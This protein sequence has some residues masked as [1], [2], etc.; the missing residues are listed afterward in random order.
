MAGLKSGLIELVEDVAPQV[1]WAHWMLNRESLVAKE[2]LCKCVSFL[3]CAAAGEEHTALL[4]HSEVRWLSCGTVL[5]HV[6]IRE[7]LLP[8]KPHRAGCKFQ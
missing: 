7:F 6:F 8:Q 2:V 4:Y 3:L 5:S 1:K